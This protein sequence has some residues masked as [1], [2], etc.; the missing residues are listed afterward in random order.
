MILDVERSVV[1]VAADRDQVSGD[2][3][4]LLDG[5]PIWNLQ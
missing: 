4:E 2:P 3:L 1:G 5:L